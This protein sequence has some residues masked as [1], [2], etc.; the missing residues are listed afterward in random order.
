MCT[1]CVNMC[2]CVYLYMYDY[3]VIDN[4]CA[5]QLLNVTGHL[6]VE[7][8]LSTPFLPSKAVVTTLLGTTGNTNFIFSNPG[9]L[10]E[11]TQTA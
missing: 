6:T 10:K 5:A 11:S 9:H 1:V 8:I 2:V 4:F 3:I 7:I